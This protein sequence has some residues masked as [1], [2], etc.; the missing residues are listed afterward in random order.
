MGNQKFTLDKA[1]TSAFDD[2]LGD[3][4]A[5]ALLFS[6]VDCQPKP[7]TS[8]PRVEP[9]SSFQ[10]NLNA[11]EIHLDPR[12]ALYILLRHND[13]LVAITFLPYLAPENQRRFLLDNRDEFLRQLGKQN[14][15][16]SL[17]CKEIGEVAYVRAW[18]ERDDNIKSA[19]AMTDECEDYQNAMSEVQDIGYKKSKCR[20]CDR[21]MKNKISGEA[22]EVFGAMSR[23]GS[24]VQM[25]V[26]ITTETIVLISAVTDISAEEVTTLLPTTKPSFT[27]YR[28][29]ISSLLYFI[30]H[31][32]DSA[33]V[34]ERMKHTMAIPGLINVH[35]E[36][37]G[38]HVDQKIE[39]HDP[40]DLVFTEKDEK[41]G[42]FRSMYLRNEYEGTE[43]V[44]DNLEK[45]ADFYKNVK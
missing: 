44:Y 15:A 31:S 40:E 32:P 17:I 5:F 34:Q 4:T 14:F 29:K 28:H 26:D 1:A 35:A 16:Q 27:F 42:K 3:A 38:V 13:S 33:S 19:S 39:I 11:L 22:L 23:P 10:A 2:F 37:A 30:F 18:D 9:A 36:D 21:R 7:L 20:A 43:S 8:I 24:L 45:D 6:L 41:V 12:T 25:T